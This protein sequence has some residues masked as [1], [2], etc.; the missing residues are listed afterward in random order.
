MEATRRYSPSVNLAWVATFVTSLFLVLLLLSATPASAAPAP[1]LNAGNAPYEPGDEEGW[2]YEEEEEGEEGEFEGEEG[3]Y[4]DELGGT[5]CELGVE[6]FEEGL[7]TLTD[8]QDL[9]AAEEEWEE[10]MEGGSESRPPCALRSA[11][12][13]AKTTKRKRLRLTIGYTTATPIA[14]RIEIRAGKK[15]LGSVKRR[16]GRR[17]VIRLTRRLGK[18]HLGKRIRLRVRLPRQGA[19]CSSQQLVLFPQ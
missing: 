10:E 1:L 7:L 4:E 9:C 12:L 13:H 16:L 17:G 2:E 18:K 11:R 14:A 3:E 19:A 5:D 15:K 6:A 8:V